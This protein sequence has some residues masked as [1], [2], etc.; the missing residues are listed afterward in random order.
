MQG[1][2]GITPNT[3]PTQGLIRLRHVALWRGIATLVFA[4]SVLA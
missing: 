4:L 2:N 1:T 3:V